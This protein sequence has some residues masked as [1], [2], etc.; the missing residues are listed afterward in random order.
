M[1]TDRQTDRDIERKSKRGRDTEI[2]KDR[3]KETETDRDQKKRGTDKETQRHEDELTTS[4]HLLSPS[5]GRTATVEN[6]GRFKGFQTC[7][8]SLSYPTQTHYAHSGP[9]QVHARQPQSVIPACAPLSRVDRLF[10]Y[11]THAALGH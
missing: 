5:L 7:G 8:D 4:T 10:R 6:P 3:Q 11:R 9:T 2:K 1:H